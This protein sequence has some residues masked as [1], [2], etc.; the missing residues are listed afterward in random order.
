PPSGNLAAYVA[1]QQG[2]AYFDLGTEASFH[3]AIDAFGEAIRLDPNYAAAY[4]RLS[5]TWAMLGDQWVGTEPMAPAYAKARAA[6]DT[7]LKLDPESALAHLA[8]A[9]LLQA[10]DFD[11]TGAE[12]ESRRALQLAPDDAGAQFALASVQGPTGKV[13]QGVDLV[14]EALVADPRRAYWY[15]RLSQYVSGLGHNNA[16]K[17]AITTAIA[18]QPTSAA[19]HAQLAMVE[20]GR[21]DAKA[22]L[23]VAQQEPDEGWRETAMTMALQVGADRAA[24]D[25]ALKTFIAKDANWGAYQIAEVYALRRDPDNTFLWLDRAWS[26]R[27]TGI[28]YLLFDPFIL[29]YRDDPRFAA[30]CKKVGLPATTDA[31]AMK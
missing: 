16:A 27:D 24:A 10:A 31:V 8:R 29:R 15:Y 22:A 23:T 17:Q 28:Y 18:L 7:A 4:A 9:F 26:N 12:S 11:W 30:F 21:G 6:V 2:N 20:I 1:Y 25:A 5:Y 13:Q 3:Q 14:R 19:F